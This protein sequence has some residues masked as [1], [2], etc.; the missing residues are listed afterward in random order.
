MSLIIDVTQLA[1]WPGKLTGV[2]RVMNE[3]VMRFAEEQGNQLVVWDGPARAFR[4]ITYQELVARRAEPELVAAAPVARAVLLKRA[5]L[6]VEARSPQAARL[7]RGVQ[8]RLHTLKQQATQPTNQPSGPVVTPR[9]EDALLVLWGA[10]H[11]P[12]YSDMLLQVHGQGVKLLQIVYDMIPLVT[13]QYAG[14]SAEALDAYATA[15]YPKCSLL[16]SISKNTKRDL[17]VWLRERKLHVPPV[18]VFRLG[19]D[20]KTAKPSKPTDPAFRSS[21]CKGGDYILTVGTIE[22]RKNHA[23]LYYVYKLAKQRGITLPKVVIVGRR[24][25]LTDDT[26]TLMTTDPEVK[27]K[28]VFLLHADGHSSTSDEELTWLFKHSLFSIYQSFYEG[29]GLPIAES[30]LYGVPCIASNTSSMTE[31]AGDLLTYF[32]P[33]STDECL[34]AIIRLLNPVELERARKRIATYVPTTWDETFRAAQGAIKKE[35]AS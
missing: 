31:I 2:P 22:A 18:A 16:L 30:I 29:W 11:D 8:H 19:D 17:E 28:F 4:P 23:L 9:A 6:A 7:R 1:E 26:F 24:G 14:H 21:G 32:S 27:D 25:W 5:V 3:L 33:V 20:F 35:L 12:A 15:I 13:P 10:W 34:Q